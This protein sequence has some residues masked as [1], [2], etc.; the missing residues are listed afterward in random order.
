MPAMILIV[1]PLRTQVSISVPDTRAAAAI[2][3]LPSA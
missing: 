3:Y 1:P 2:Q